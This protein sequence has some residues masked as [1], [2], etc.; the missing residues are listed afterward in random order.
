MANLMNGGLDRFRHGNRQRTHGREFIRIFIQGIRAQQT[1]G[2]GKIRDNLNK[3][4]SFGRRDP[5]QVHPSLQ[6][7]EFKQRLNK[8]YPFDGHV[9]TIQ[10]MAVTDVSPAYQNTIGTTLQGAQNM[11][12]GNRCRAHDPY[13]TDVGGIRH[14]ADTG[15]V[16]STVRTPVA[17]KGDYFRFKSFITHCFLLVKYFSFFWVRIGFRALY[18]A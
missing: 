1:D 15:Q 2:F 11:M 8:C 12:C 7:D 17:Q 16:R 6:T 5:F 10:V 4:L 14:P 18:R 9:I 13:R 3:F